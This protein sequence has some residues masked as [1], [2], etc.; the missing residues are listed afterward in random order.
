ML[1]QSDEDTVYL[2]ASSRCV[3]AVACLL[4][5]AHPVQS[6]E[7]NPGALRTIKVKIAIDEEFRQ[8][9]LQWLKAEKWVSTASR[10]FET[11]FGVSFKVSGFKSWTSDNSKTA[12]PGLLQ[13]L[14]EKIGREGSDIV[15]GFTGQIRGDSRATGVASYR[16]GYALVKRMKNEYITALTVVH[17]LCHL[18]GAVD[19]EKESSI[20]NKDEPRL[21][22]DEFTSRI[23]R[24]HLGRSFDPAVFP[25]SAEDMSSAM[26]LYQER[27]KLHRSEEGVPLMLTIIYLE[28]KD[29]DKAVKECLE[30]EK[31][32][33]H[34]PL[35]QELLKLTSQKREEPSICPRAG[36]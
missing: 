3:L 31:L 18:F 20:M 34:D 11:N 16:H 14:Y 7:A 23:I 13:N 1:R 15:L 22:C 12:L 5:A 8:Q 25:L 33:P 35:I 17:E 2:M 29:Y 9:P 28:M 27:K 6:G 10:F 19:L 4:A 32:A 30:A 21:E 36:M 24:L 26:N